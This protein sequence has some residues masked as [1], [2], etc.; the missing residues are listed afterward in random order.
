MNPPQVVS[1]KPVG[2]V[3]TDAAGDEVKDRTR[4]SEIVIHPESCNRSR[5]DNQLFAYLC[6]VLDA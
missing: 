3:K 4:T 2:Y 5:R 1:M 6:A